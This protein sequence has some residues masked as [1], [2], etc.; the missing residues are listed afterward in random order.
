MGYRGVQSWNPCPVERFSVRIPLET[1]GHTRDR[2]PLMSSRHNDQGRMDLAR[3]V[4]I[5][6][7]ESMISGPYYIVVHR[8]HLR[9]T[10]DTL[11]SVT[12][13]LRLYERSVPSICKIFSR[14]GAEWPLLDADTYTHTRLCQEN[15]A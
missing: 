11:S 8:T 6:I 5:L 13:G 7:Q 15:D 9:C 2:Q 10:H 14:C 1:R 4:L 12:A 3:P